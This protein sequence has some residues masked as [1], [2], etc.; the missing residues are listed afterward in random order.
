MI[1]KTHT[2]RSLALAA[3]VALAGIASAQN[4]VPNPS[5]EGVDEET[6][7][8]D[9]KTFGLIN[10]ISNDWEAPQRCPRT[11]SWCAT[12]PAR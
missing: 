7:E 8:K 2:L 1:L 9:I 4:L 5:F 11:C 3:T 10:T 12:S 6:K